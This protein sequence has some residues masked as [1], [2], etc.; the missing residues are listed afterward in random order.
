MC[1]VA[2]DNQGDDGQG[3][4]FQHVGFAEVARISGF[5]KTGNSAWGARTF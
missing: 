5:V 2:P 1:G 4:M 3:D